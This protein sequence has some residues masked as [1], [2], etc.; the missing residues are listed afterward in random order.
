LHDAAALVATAHGLHA[1]AGAALVTAGIGATDA[2]IVA[3]RLG[4]PSLAFGRLIEAP[5]PLQEAATH[6]AA[7]VAVALVGGGMVGR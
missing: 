7:A 2:A 5:A 6:H 4:W 1:E 3:D